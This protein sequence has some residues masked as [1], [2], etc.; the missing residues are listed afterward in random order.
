MYCTN[1][2][3]ENRDQSKFCRDCGQP[4]GQHPPVSPPPSPIPDQA[5]THV[6]RPPVSPTPPPPG[7]Q[8]YRPQ[9]NVPPA[10]SPATP[11][12]DAQKKRRNRLILIG[13]GTGVFLCAIVLVLAVIFLPSLLQG[14]DRM[15]VSFPN[16]DGESDLYLLKTGQAQED[17]TLLAENLVIANRTYMWYR[18]TE[19]TMSNPGS[20]YAMFIPDTNRLFYWAQDDDKATV[21]GMTIGDDTAYEVISTSA[22]PLFTLTFE[23]SNYVFVQETREDQERCY[24]GK[25]GEEPLRLGKGDTCWFVWNGSSSYAQTV[26]GGQTTFSLIG[27]DGKDETTLLDDMEDVVENSLRLS[28]DGSHL[29][30]ATETNHGQQLY[31]LSKAEGTPTAVGSEVFSLLAHAFI[32]KQDTLYYLAEN[33]DGEVELYLSDKGLVA[34]GA[35]IAATSDREGKHLIYQVADEDGEMTLFSRP[36]NSDTGQEIMRS[37]GLEFNLLQTN[38]PKIVAQVV[39][40]DEFTLYTADLDGSNLLE[41]FNETNLNDL[42]ILYVPQG[43][44]FFIEYENDKGA[45]SLDAVPLDTAEG[46]LLVDEWDSLQLA[47]LSP[48]GKTLVLIG[49]E[50][51]GDDPVLYSLAVDAGASLIKLDDD[52]Q[53]F[54]N[55]VL[56]QNGKDVIYTAVTGDNPDDVEIYQ[57]PVDGSKSRESLYHEA[58]LEDVQWMQMSPFIG[59][60]WQN[61][62]EGTSYCPGAP[63]LAVGDSHENQLP[64]RETQC[65]RFHANAG[66]FLSFDV[67]TVAEDRYDLNMTLYD[68]DGT[69]LAYNNDDP[70][71]RDPQLSFLIPETGVYFA[72]VS[73]YIDAEVPYTLKVFEGPVEASA[74]DAQ[75]LEGGSR[76]RG[77]ITDQNSIR[78]ERHDFDGYGVFYY[79]D[80]QAGETITIDVYAES[81]GSTL[82]PQIVLLDAAFDDLYSDDDSGNGSEAHLKYVLPESTRYYFLVAGPNGDQ[83]GTEAAFFYEIA[84]TVTP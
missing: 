1:C 61:L 82:D 63:S 31:L 22:L 74:R 13:A 9:P 33:E 60:W 38:P 6:V 3:A 2:G 17:G 51:S 36:L 64:A 80:G 69:N 47:N 21:Y 11:T 65:Y 62:V 48:N 34:T 30:Y 53:G 40:N 12:S 23:N 8:P 4:L 79:Y 75:R 29:A 42:T 78:L 66:D 67:D 71:G 83:Y 24:A 19:E 39:D 14:T 56:T 26:D 57:V 25:F 41:V 49:R 68:R 81:L 58:V 7:P 44:T 77:A 84:L 55:A 73:G 46:F 16:R 70:F 72:K 54:R 59:V 45:I 28:D 35:Q 15:L 20:R 37:D 50:D 27:M 5:P 52:S 76:L 18:T 43:K 10:A 32:S